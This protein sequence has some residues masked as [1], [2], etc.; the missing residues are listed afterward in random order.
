ML[1]WTSFYIYPYKFVW[2]FI[3]MIY[4]WV[5]LLGQRA[6]IYWISF[7]SD[8]LLRMTVLFALPP[9]LLEGSYLST[10]SPT[11]G[12]SCLSKI[13]HLWRV[14]NDISLLFQFGFFWFLVIFE[15]FFICLLAIWAS[16]LWIAYSYLLH[17]FLF[18]T[19]VFFSM[20]F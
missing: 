17:F 1:Q 19:W 7:T 4:P 10:S 8:L 3:W 5:G 13:C 11:H 20:S 15:H 12:I 6:Y 18:C 14:K 16:H 2:A 9:A